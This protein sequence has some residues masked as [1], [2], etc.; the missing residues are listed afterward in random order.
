MALVI[1]VLDW[2]VHKHVAGFNQLMVS[3]LSHS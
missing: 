3:Q 1:L 2:D